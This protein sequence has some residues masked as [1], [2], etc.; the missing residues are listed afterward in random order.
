MDE[1]LQRAAF[2][3]YLVEFGG[4]IFAVATC[5]YTARREPGPAL[6][7]WMVVILSFFG[8]AAH[9]SAHPHRTGRAR[10][11]GRPG[12]PGRSVRPVRA[13]G[14]LLLMGLIALLFA[15]YFR[16]G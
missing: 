13:I 4:T 3:Y 6:F 7:S 14:R 16:V 5:A 15:A 8:G 10:H 12:Q 1:H 11:A 2:V 9:A